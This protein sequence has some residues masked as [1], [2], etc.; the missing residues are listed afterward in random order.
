M[1]RRLRP[2]PFAAAKAASVGRSYSLAWP[3]STFLFLKSSAPSFNFAALGGCA[4]IKG[5][6]HRIGPQCKGLPPVRSKTVE[7]RRAAV[8][9]SAQTFICSKLIWPLHIVYTLPQVINARAAAEVTCV[10]KPPAIIP[11]VITS[12][13]DFIAAGRVRPSEQLI[14]LQQVSAGHPHGFP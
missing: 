3:S 13:Q 9:D 1:V 12:V 7:R 11:M 10:S 14:D 8:F 2:R 5:Q 6:R 4:W